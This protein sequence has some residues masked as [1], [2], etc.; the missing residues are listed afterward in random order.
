MRN[1]VSLQH[2]AVKAGVTKGTVSL[3]LRNH[4]RISAATPVRVQA[5]A[6]E[7]GYRP[8]PAVAAW[9]SHRRGVAPKTGGASIAFF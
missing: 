3:A 6:A 2:I 1:A 7:L 9:M 4:P 8:N 5:V